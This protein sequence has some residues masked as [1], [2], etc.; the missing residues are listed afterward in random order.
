M[1]IGNILLLLGMHRLESL[2]LC[3]AEK[4]IA[5]LIVEVMSQGETMLKAEIIESLEKS[6][7]NTQL[8]VKNMKLYLV[9]FRKDS[10]QGTFQS[11]T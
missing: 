9:L 7:V 10:K 5:S 2:Y 6:T 3:Q 1:Q 4:V 11:W 8:I